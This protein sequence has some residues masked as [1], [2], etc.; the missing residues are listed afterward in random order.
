[1]LFSALAMSTITSEPTRSLAAGQNGCHDAPC[2]H[3]HR[4]HEQQKSHWRE[5]DE[6]D[7]TSEREGNCDT[8]GVEAIDRWTHVGFITIRFRDYPVSDQFNGKF[9]Q[10]FPTFRRA[11][12][13]RASQL[14]R[15]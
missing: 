11:A 4:S 13:D 15:Q 14:P 6:Q 12:I 3:E 10:L 9:P 8:E 1:M 2:G 7:R 5:Q